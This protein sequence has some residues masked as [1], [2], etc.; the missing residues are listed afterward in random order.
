MTQR[1]LS[2]AALACA[3]TAAT[4][5]AQAQEQA[6]PPAQ[7]ASAARPPARPASAPGATK[8]DR[9]EVTGGRANETEQRR[10]STAAKIIIGRDEIERYGDS[11]VGEVLKRLPGVTMQGAPGRGGN[12]RMR[13]LGGGY[14]QILLDGERVPPGFSLDSLTP[15]QIER[16]EVL[17]APTAETGARA[18][19]G[20]INIITREGF[21]KR[22]NDLRIGAQFE[23]GHVNPGLSWTRNEALGPWTVNVSLTA[24]SGKRESESTTET[25]RQ[26]PTDPAPTMAR[27]EHSLS[28]DTRHGLH[29]T[30]R[31]QWRGEKGESLTLMPIIIANSGS[32]ARQSQI[33]QIVDDPARPAGYDHSASTSDNEFLL[34]RLNA[35]YN[36]ALTPSTRLEWR[37]GL[38]RAHSR[39]RSSRNEFDAS[40]AFTRRLD[41]DADVHDDSGNLSLKWLTQLDSEHSLVF[42]AETEATRRN[43]LRTT[44]QTTPAGGTVP[45][46][47][48][49]G[50]NFRA[51]TSRVALYG[52][53]EWNISPTV[54]AHA[55]IRWEGIDT[56]SDA[57]G[58]GAD[59]GPVHNRSSV[60]TPIA[61]AVWKPEPNSRDQVRLSLTRSYKSPTLNNLIGR[62]SVSSRFPVDGP[63]NDATSPDRVG[64]PDLKPEL[65]RGIDLAFEHYIKGGGLL[66][67]NVFH[68]DITNLI[69]TLTAVETPWW[70]GGKPRYVA[71]PQNIGDAVTQ[72]I[73]LEAKF[74]ASDVWEGAIPLDVRTNASFFQSRVKSV[75]GPDN[76]LD[77]QPSATANLGFDYRFRGM[78]LTVGGNYNWNPAYNTRLSEDQYAYQGAKRVLDAYALWVFNPALQLR[79][80]GSNLTALDYVTGST[81]APET[82][83]TIAKSYV[84]WQVRL[85]MK[86]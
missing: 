57:G 55:G 24:F 6:N 12:I 52:Q 8:L 23:N 56:R 32:G 85:E 54:A 19:A 27:S 67:A 34:T 41:D 4:F 46:Y 74:R 31:L 77:Q 18:I 82:A 40:D 36:H 86:L 53:D 65:A 21:R 71:R 69:R 81:I 51:S 16:I 22:L 59:G 48:D 72:G 75:P 14:T 38:G 84:N 80:S 35:Q 45:L 17:R 66:S 79:V 10:Q 2:H 9:V 76:R 11:T 70:S 37:A 26:G 44:F 47:D 68:R 64:N 43:E 73:E 39:N 3:A 1:L 50:D 42:G 62:P 5:A 78:P 33:T 13:G 25:A 7:A 83:T 29:L 20:T 61:H 58:A 60:V 49:L 30:S 63:I 28:E 15:E